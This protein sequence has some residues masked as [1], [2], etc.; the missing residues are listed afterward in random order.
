MLGTTVKQP[1]HC[2]LILVAL[3]LIPDAE[4]IIP[5]TLTNL[6]IISDFIFLSTTGLSSEVKS[7]CTSLTISSPSGRG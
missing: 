1:L 5:E 2:I 6:E 4:T 7:T 3:L